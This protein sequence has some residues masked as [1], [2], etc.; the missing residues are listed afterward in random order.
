V[1]LVPPGIEPNIH[2]RMHS[3][4][5]SLTLEIQLILKL[6]YFFKFYLLVLQFFTY[7]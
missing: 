6:S 4:A 2:F 5:I 7:M 3:N 1:D